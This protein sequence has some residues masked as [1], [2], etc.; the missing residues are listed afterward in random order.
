MKEFIACI[1]FLLAPRFSFELESKMINSDIKLNPL[2]ESFYIHTTWFDFPQFGRAPSNGLIFIK[3]G[4]ALLVDTP[5]TNAQTET[6]YRF[7]RDSL[8][9]NIEIAIVGH[10]HSD[11]M[12]GLEILHSM[13]IQSICSEKTRQICI[14]ENLPVPSES[15]RD[16][17]I[18]KFEGE[19]VI[20]R[21]FGGGHSI[22]N[23][24]VYFPDSKI[25]FGGC[26]I[27]SL[28]SRGLGNIAE[29]D[30]SQWDET[31]EKVKTMWPSIR[32]VVP[33]HG[34]AGDARLLDHTINL[35]R[36]YREKLNSKK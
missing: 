21:Y 14:S 16:S 9:A 11:C 6:L 10:S 30:V 13:G 18:F 36:Q 8:H 12:G 17:L 2:D 4:R 7:V 25:L 26:L 22:D 27:K 20:C 31:V 28:A 5:N 35:V 19:K 34:A 32:I 1:L 23:I 3:N 15:F 33:G 29:A 24:V